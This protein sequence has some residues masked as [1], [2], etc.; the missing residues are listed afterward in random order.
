M[1]FL[2]FPFLF[3]IIPLWIIDYLLN[4]NEILLKSK[5]KWKISEEI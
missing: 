2:L 4:D 5:K 1:N 3:A